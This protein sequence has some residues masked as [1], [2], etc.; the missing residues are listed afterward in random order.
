MTHPGSDHRDDRRHHRLTRRGQY[1]RF[2]ISMDKIL[3]QVHPAL[4][5][6]ASE[7]TAKQ[8]DCSD[9]ACV[10][11]GT[12][13]PVE[14][15]APNARAAT[16]GTP[17]MPRPSIVT[18]FCLRMA[19]TALMTCSPLYTFPFECPFAIRRVPGWDG[20]NVLQMRSPMPASTTGRIV[21]GCRTLAP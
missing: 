11:S 9:E 13:V 17:S 14:A 2:E 15:T 18:N 12:L 4:D 3:F 20:L 19:V 1:R 8:M 16:P 21:F 6:A 10:M 5:R 7:G